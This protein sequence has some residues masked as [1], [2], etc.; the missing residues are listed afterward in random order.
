M[1]TA[2]AMAALSLAQL[3]VTLV[4]LRHWRS[5]L[6]GSGKERQAEPAAMAAEARRMAGAVERAAERLPFATKCLPRAVAL[7]W[8]LRRSAIGHALVIAVRPPHLRDAADALHAWVK[9]DGAKIL[10]ESPGPWFETL[11]TGAGRHGIQ[12]ASC[13]SKRS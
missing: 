6:G 2:Q 13:N 1:R 11:R 9:V 7:S 8:L 5:T 12:P 3:T 4:P 10:G